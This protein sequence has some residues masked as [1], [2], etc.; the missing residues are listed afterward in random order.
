MGV[1]THGTTAE[2]GNLSLLDGRSHVCDKHQGCK[3]HEDN[4]CS[5]VDLVL[6]WL[7]EREKKDFETVISPERR[8]WVSGDEVRD[9]PSQRERGRADAMW[10][11]IRV[12]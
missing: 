1:R 9:G 3:G 8:I 11:I 6:G 12:S 7:V 2:D 10:L 5:Q 4:R